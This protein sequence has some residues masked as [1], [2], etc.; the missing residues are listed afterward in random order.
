MLVFSGIFLLLVM[1][2]GSL[3]FVQQKL[4]LAKQNREQAFRFAETGIEYY[5]WFLAHFPTDFQNGTGASGPYV[6]PVV[7]PEGGT[8]GQ[9]SLTVDANTYCGLV[10]SVDLT[11]T[12]ETSADPTFKRTLIARYA[13]PSVADYAYVLNSNVWAG[14]DR[15]INGKY[16]S[17]GGITMD[18][19]V[20]S[21]VLSAVATWVCTSSY[22]CNNPNQTKPGV[23]G[24]GTN[25]QYWRYP[26]PQIDFAGISAD[27]VSMK[28]AAQA[29]GR[30]F[31][32]SGAEGYHVVFNA[33]GSFDVYTVTQTTSIKGNNG[34]GV[35][36]EK[37]IIAAET[38][39]GNYTSPAGCGLIFIEDT[40]WVEGVVKGKK[41]IVA[42]DVTTP[43]VDRSVWL[44]N[45][46]TY[47]NSDGSDGLMV[48]AE[49]DNLITLNSPEDM[50]LMGVFVAQNGRFGRNHYTAGGSNQV[51]PAYGL[52]TVRDT[53]III[54]TIVSNGREGTKWTQGNNNFVS[55]Y[56]YRFNS[57][58]RK[59][60]SDPPPYT[61]FTSSDYRLVDWKEQ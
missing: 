12:G 29:Q 15:I 34:N 41:S 57:Y 5:K 20:N 61:P 44:L 54:G 9:Y 33:N 50:T 26:V 58:D 35:G 40:L 21:E 1:S 7:D 19:V 55:G 23:W 59:L 60:A 46:L 13:R 10:G 4:S 47:A 48:L 52:Y 3:I 22:N 49:L 51:P 17:N 25:Q 42:A 37:S 30:Y 39:L 38:L 6:V 31:A 24:L 27:L 8:I 43:N 18:G 45:N 28:A 11:S 32:P 36:N 14:A 2:L 16:H 53:L 56:Q